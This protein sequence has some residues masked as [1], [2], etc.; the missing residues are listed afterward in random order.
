MRF[1]FWLKGGV[2]SDGLYVVIDAFIDYKPI[3][4]H[5]SCEDTL[6][7]HFEK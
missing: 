1:V 7:I 3:T 4:F 2:V 5:T 6:G